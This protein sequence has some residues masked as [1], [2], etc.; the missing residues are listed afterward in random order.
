M[1]GLREAIFENEPVLFYPFDGENWIEEDGYLPDESPEVIMDAMGHKNA[2]LCDTPALNCPWKGYR[3]RPSLC[4]IEVDGHACSFGFDGYYEQKDDAGKLVNWYGPNSYVEIPHGEY[5]TFPQNR[6][7]IECLFHISYMRGSNFGNGTTYGWVFSKPGLITAQIISSMQRYFLRVSTSSGE[8]VDIDVQQNRTYHLVVNYQAAGGLDVYL[9]CE[10][11]VDHRLQ[12]P[13]NQ[14]NRPRTLNVG[15]PLYLGSIPGDPK[16]LRRTEAVTLDYVAIYDY[17]LP[18][19]EIVRHHKKLR[20]YW[21]TVKHHG[22][23]NILPLSDQISP[24]HK[25]CNYGSS[26]AAGYY[27]PSC[28]LRVDGPESIPQSYGIR[29]PNKG[30]AIYGALELRFM[31]GTIEF[32]FMGTN[33]RQRECIFHADNGTFPSRGLQ[34][35]SDS[36]MNEYMRGSLEFVLK[37]DLRFST[38]SQDGKNW[39]DGYWHHVCVI[40]QNSRLKVYVDMV[41]YEWVLNEGAYPYLS[42]SRWAFGCSRNTGYS[43]V[44]IS[45]FAIYWRALTPMQVNVHYTYGIINRIKGIVTLQGVPLA[46]TVRAYNHETGRLAYETISDPVT[47]EYEMS[48]LDN[49]RIDLMVFDRGNE[50][51]RYRAVGPIEPDKYIDI[52]FLL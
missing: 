30:P 35:W 11:A 20:T 47:G 8:A 5:T 6:M 15:G 42:M 27:D 36:N 14:H 40:M 17:C 43:T 52:P 25:V 32:W 33:S 51:I 44:A 29:N 18:E 4:E 34:I 16:S 46:A 2:I 10:N 45:N 23:R 7:S 21:G 37:D 26:D 39:M 50:N 48:L 9:D 12:L 19:S 13:E 22:A 28:Q 38:G 24:E 49:S 41:E 3:A 31:T 1:S